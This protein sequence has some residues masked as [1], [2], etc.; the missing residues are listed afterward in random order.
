MRRLL[1]LSL[2]LLVVDLPAPVA[3][4]EGMLSGNGRPDAPLALIAA[5]LATLALRM[6][7]YSAGANASHMFPGRHRKQR[8]F[9][10]QPPPAMTSIN[11]GVALSVPLE[12]HGHN[13]TMVT[14]AK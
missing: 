12:F 11:S 13:L 10:Y 2:L 3:C 4:D 7:R 8:M 1:G 5:D 9:G 6:A 14:L